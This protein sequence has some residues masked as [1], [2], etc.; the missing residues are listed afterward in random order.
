MH[1]FE[2]DNKCGILQLKRNTVSQTMHSMTNGDF[3]MAVLLWLGEAQGL[4]VL[5]LVLYQVGL[6]D[7]RVV[8]LQQ[9]QVKV[10]YTRDRRDLLL[11]RHSLTRGI[12]ATQLT[13]SDKLGS[14]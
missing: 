10:E 5:Q 11:L 12:R 1:T 4:Q 8:V 3:S 2:C 13:G 9:V 7:G 6:G 14:W